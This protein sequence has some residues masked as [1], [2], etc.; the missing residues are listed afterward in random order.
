[1]TFLLMF[2]ILIV[3]MLVTGYGADGAQHRCWTLD[4]ETGSRIVEFWLGLGR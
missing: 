2:L 3:V 4:A 1:M